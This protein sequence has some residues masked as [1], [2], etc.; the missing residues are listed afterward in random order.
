MLDIDNARENMSEEI[1]RWTKE[2]DIKIHGTTPYHH[3]SNGRIERFNRTIGEGLRKSGI[4]GVLAV[5]LKRI[6]D[7][8]NS[9]EHSAIGMAPNEALNCENW[10]EIKRKTF[11]N[12]V[13][14]YKKRFK[15]KKTEKVKKT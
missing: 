1:K 12:R 14:K 7:I 13:E 2:E 6:V 11:E 8:Y 10:T 4:K 15:P 5:R 9:V 3:Q